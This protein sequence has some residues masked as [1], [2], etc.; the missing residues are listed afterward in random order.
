MLINR[1]NNL[2]IRSKF[3]LLYVLGVFLPLSLILTF[4]TNAVTEEIRHR[5]EK[6]AE[7]SFERDQYGRVYQIPP[8]GRILR[9]DTVL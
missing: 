5:E 3:I 2:R 9:A 7:I 8:R 1:I 4:F 6:N